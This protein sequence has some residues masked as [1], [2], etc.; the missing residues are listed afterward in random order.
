MN[1]DTP[2]AP[3]SESSTVEVRHTSVSTLIP[4][5]LRD[6]VRQAVY[7]RTCEDHSTIVDQSVMGFSGVFV[8]EH[9]K[10]REPELWTGVE[11]SGLRRFQR[12]GLAGEEANAALLESLLP[13]NPSD[14]LDPDFFSMDADGLRWV[15]TLASGANLSYETAEPVLPE[16]RQKIDGMV[17]EVLRCADKTGLLR[18]GWTLLMR[19]P[20]PGATDEEKQACDAVVT[21]QTARYADFLDTLGDDVRKQAEKDL[22]ELYVKG[23]SSKRQ[24]SAMRQEPRLRRVLAPAVRQT[25][26]TLMAKAE[27]LISESDRAY[28]VE[29]MQHLAVAEESPAEVS[30]AQA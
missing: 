14:T 11:L 10:D 15:L 3:A 30:N 16:T 25:A 4:H 19:V 2:T 20:F 22:V 26:A 7:L 27:G 29:F 18:I 1:P 5:S 12:H 6:L 17:D 24:L 28:L 13:V 9:V 21:S 8:R 23:T